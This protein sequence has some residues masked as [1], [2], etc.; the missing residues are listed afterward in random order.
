MN[1]S[2]SSKPVNIND[3]MDDF[4]RI[5]GVLKTNYVKIFLDT[6]GQE[7]NN[8]PIFISLKLKELAGVKKYEPLLMMFKEEPEKFFWSFEERLLGLAE[9]SDKEIVNLFKGRSGGHINIIP[10]YEGVEWLKIVKSSFKEDFTLLREKIVLF[11]ARF[12]S[13]GLERIVEFKKMWWSCLS[14]G[15][16]FETVPVYRKTREKYKTPSFCTN[17][18]C[19]ARNKS[20]F[21]LVQEK[22]EYFEKRAFTIINQENQEVVNELRCYIISD[23]E[24]FIE[25]MK[26]VHCNEEI[27]VLGIL[28]MDTAD[29]FSRSEFHSDPF[30]YIE[31]I[32]I[33]IGT[34]K[35]LNQEIIKQ[36][37]KEMD[38]NPYY[39]NTIIDSI[40][41][42]SQDIINFFPV[43]LL[44]TLAHI[45]ADS[46]D[47]Q[48][49]GINYIVGSHAGALKSRIA[50]SFQ[51]ILG[52]TEFG[53]IYGKG[54]TGK[55]L[56]PVAQRN[57]G[58]KD[59]IKR[60]GAIPYYTRKHLLINEAQYM[61]R[62]DPDAL[63]CFKFYEDGIITRC[64]DGTTI[65]VEAQ[66]TFGF[67]LNY[68]TEDEAY[69][70]DKPLTENLGFPGDQ[71]SILDR[72]DLHYIIPRIT[73]YINR[74]LN[75]RDSDSWSPR[76]QL[77]EAI[78]YNYLMEG[79]RVYTN[80]VTITRPIE[81]II[82]RLYEAIISTETN[83]YSKRILNP[84]DP[85]ILKKLLKGIAALRLR[86]HVIE[87]DIEYMKRFL[88][89]TIIP[90][91][92]AILIKERI[93]D[94]DEIFKNVFN[95]LTELYDTSINISDFIH[96]LREYIE[97]NYFIEKEG[98]LANL[99]PPKLNLSNQKFRTLLE[100]NMSYITGQGW[101]IILINNKTHLINKERMKEIIKE[102][103]SEFFRDNNATI[104]APNGL[105]QAL[106]I[107]LNYPGEMIEN[108]IEELIQEGFVKK[109]GAQLELV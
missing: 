32:E 49:N 98:V 109:K 62:S 23:V 100:R 75:R 6:L 68:K 69:D 28:K 15:T 64:L 85:R 86:D 1:F 102:G 12:L 42:Y 95:L 82:E 80:G 2:E 55:G 14:C 3:I 91:Q 106:E 16:E 41:P 9:M 72:I 59:L 94:K 54:T 74:V 24:Y 89:Q 48:R 81:K 57:N 103:I 79:K 77:S 66:G 18:N 71:Q 63:E 21:R 70:Y 67:A 20:D 8:N 25:K 104:V 53:I 60:Y 92:E 108:F 107:T 33:Y 4:L 84:R 99:M 17:K 45:T 73:P 47:I 29:L 65:Y 56:I 30:Y 40:H 36:I 105:I 19:K 96:F 61:Y 39:C 58:E 83:N 7:G 50:T 35:I 26:N 13:L 44:M 90:F 51:R 78:I 22:S 5:N 87:E 52:S 38:A 43:K 93:I 11:K 10:D 37:R 101:E 31:V 27:D 88:I 46:F 76:V 97:S 34:S